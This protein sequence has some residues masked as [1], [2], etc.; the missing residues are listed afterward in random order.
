VNI[1]TNYSYLLTQKYNLSLIWTFILTSVASLDEE[2]F[3]K[4]KSW[5]QSLIR[6]STLIT[7]T[8]E[9]QRIVFFEKQREIINEL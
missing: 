1:E 4:M 3:Y 6:T 8:G 9:K 7:I 5:F 2:A